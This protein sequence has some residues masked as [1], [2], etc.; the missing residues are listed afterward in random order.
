MGI[1]LAPIFGNF[2]SVNNLVEI[3][4]AYADPVISTNP[5]SVLSTSAVFSITIQNTESGYVGN[6]LEWEVLRL[7]YNPTQPLV[8]AG[9]IPITNN[10]ATQTVT[11][12]VSGLTANT[13]YRFRARIVRIQGSVIFRAERD[14]TTSQDNNTQG[15]VGDQDNVSQD[16]LTSQNPD[17]FLDSSIGASDGGIGQFGGDPLVNDF[18]CGLDPLTWHKCLIQ[19]FYYLVFTPVAFLAEIAAKVMDFFIYYSVST[20]AYNSGNNFI[21]RGWEAVR[22][23]ANILFIIS[24]IYI[25]IKVVLGIDAS[26]AK[27]FVVWVIIMALLINF[28]L[29][30]TKVVI[31]ASNILTRV[32]YSAIEPKTRAGGEIVIRPGGEKPISAMLVRQFEPKRM[33]DSTPG[34]I[35][36]N[37]GLFFTAIVLATIV[38]A[39]MFF[40]FL[41]VAFLFVARV[42]SLWIAMIFS[43]VAFASYAFPSAIPGIGHQ[44]WWPELMKN[45]FLAPI[46]VFFLYII[47]MFADLLQIVTYSDSATGQ[48]KFATYMAVIIPFMIVLALL[49]K[50]K[51]LANEYAGE[52]G[53][54]VIGAVK[55]GAGLVGGLAM[56]GAALAARGTIGAMASARINASSRLPEELAKTGAKTKMSLQGVWSRATSFVSKPFGYIRRPTIKPG[57]TPEADEALRRSQEKKQ[58][59]DSKNRGLLP[60]SAFR[61]TGLQAA[62]SIT[63]Q[64]SVEEV[65]AEGYV[66]VRGAVAENLRKKGILPPRSETTNT[67][68]GQ[69]TQENQAS[70]IPISDE[71]KLRQERNREMREQERKEKER[72]TNA[73]LVE[74]TQENLDEGRRRAETSQ[75]PT[76]QYSGGMTQTGAGGASVVNIPSGATINVGGGAT[77]QGG[78]GAGAPIVNTPSTQTAGGAQTTT[79]TDKK[80]DQDKKDEE[81]VK[82]E[83]QDEEDIMT[84]VREKGASA[85]SLPDV[86][87]DLKSKRVLKDR[88]SEGGITGIIAK[89]EFNILD[90]LSK[91]SFDLRNSKIFQKLN[92]FTGIDFGGGKGQGG[93]EKMQ[94]DKERRQIEISKRLMPAK[95]ELAVL[96]SLSEDKLSIENEYK[97][98]AKRLNLSADNRKEFV[99]LALE[100]DEN[101]QEIKTSHAQETSRINNIRYNRRNNFA[102]FVA[103]GGGNIG[104]YILSTGGM[105]NPGN[106]AISQKAR[107]LQEEY[108]GTETLSPDFR[109]MMEQLKKTQQAVADLQNK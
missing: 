103:R 81:L 69:G 70:P 5:T 83:L 26:G 68:G 105:Y 40:V 74:G 57:A 51:K 84:V 104:D 60:R 41:S 99:R 9:T 12:N 87:T 85:F 16:T 39:Y 109:M 22:D 78:G 67:E 36:D 35:E 88:M 55:T 37:P 49:N 28:S 48:D 95:Q 52:M 3:N 20:I 21:Q 66:T 102:D 61:T 18:G 47:A 80:T 89:Q 92:S 43:P 23:I 71:D 14:F 33:M 86:T 13:Q 79:P 11:A 1:F 42:I 50:A 6:R 64:G 54:T 10:T 76:P 46:F 90:K 73:G 93:Y 53:Q 38:M 44:N 2:S 4:K 58:I 91:S 31:D 8:R 65:G 29:F 72:L 96:Q 17:P 15:Q 7:P 75:Q 94:E 59:A 45:A 63:G 97:E 108:E 24:L 98:I 106:I 62:R 100:K 27:R 82:K 101:Y 107:E 56:G 19:L 30:T 32:F 25:A 77:I 34:G